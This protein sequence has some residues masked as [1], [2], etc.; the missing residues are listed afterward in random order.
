MAPNK[1]LI[2]RSQNTKYRLDGILPPNGLED[3]E[4][5]SQP[6]P[7]QLKYSD[8]ELPAKIDLRDYMTP[9]EFQDTTGSW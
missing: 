3:N 7:D 6:F 2:N 5:L 9:V 1:Y 8:E 4:Q